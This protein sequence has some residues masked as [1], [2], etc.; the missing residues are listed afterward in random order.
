MPMYEYECECGHADTIFMQMKDCNEHTIVMPC[1]KCAGNF[2]RQVSVPHTDLKE[3]HKPIE[4][5]SIAMEDREEIEAFAK[6]CPD[7]DVSLDETSELYGVPV[8]RTR[9]AKLQALK[10]AGFVETK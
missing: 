3:F 7:V 6:R 8:A 5:L 9:K 10:A 1:P 2:R 4:L